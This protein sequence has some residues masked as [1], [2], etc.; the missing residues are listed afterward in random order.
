[1]T[2]ASTHM[3]DVGPLHWGWGGGGARTCARQFYLPPL[4]SRSEMGGGSGSSHITPCGVCRCMK[5][6]TRSCDCHV[7]SHDITHAIS[8]LPAPPT[9]LTS[10]LVTRSLASC[11]GSSPS[12]SSVVRLRLSLSSKRIRI[13]SWG[14]GWGWGGGGHFQPT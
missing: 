14:K 9:S 11:S 3:L 1:M 13:C 6:G 4:P 7:M 2:S 5:M 8:P 10:P 12:F